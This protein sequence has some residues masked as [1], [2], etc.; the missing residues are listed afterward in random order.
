MTSPRPDSPSPSGGAFPVEDLRSG[1]VVFL[2]A[3]PLCLGIALASGAPLFSGVI[4]GIIGGLVVSLLSSSSVSVSGPAAGLAV[5][6]ATAIQSLGSF[7][8][9]LLAVLIAGIMQIG[10]GL[11]RAGRVA[12]F[13][14][15]AVIKGMLAAIGVVIILKQ[16][17]HA[18]GR[19]KS[20]EG[21][22]DFFRADDGASTTLSDIAD[23]IATANI[24]AVL[25]AAVSLAILIAW[26]SARVK[27]HKR[28][29][30]IPGALLV[31][32]VGIT[33]NEIFRAFFTDFYLRAEDGHL[34][35]LPAGGARTLLAQITSPDWSRWN[36]ARVYSTAITLAVVASI[37][38]L[39]SLEAS[40]KIDPQR[41]ISEPNRELIAQ[42]VGNIAA[43]M[44][45]GLPVTA[46]I[47]RSSAN[48]YAGARTRWSSFIHG[49]LLLVCVVA[50]PALLNR[51]PLASLAAVL[52]MVGYKLTKPAL[53]QT[54]YKA[55]TNQF[56]PFMVT[57]LAIVFTDLLTGVLV[58][59]VFG[60]FFVVRTNQHSAFTLVRQ[61]AM[62][63]LRFNK[64]ASFV[65]KTELKSKLMNLPSDSS[66]II[67][68]TKAVFIDDDIYD[69][70]VD[71][72]EGASHKRIDI[73]FKQFFDKTQNYRK[74]RLTHG[75]A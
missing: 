11:V 53:Y 70:V 75:V 52:I 19:D 46:V 66:L 6:V 49:V 37:Q 15:N 51:I 10:F 22:F 13:V 40:D 73:E 12:D 31:V 44:L 5:I 28:L 25:I 48:V 1:L 69:V 8:A 14:P 16:I 7:S 18:L 36:D 17:P 23:A 68:G 24:E 4:S 2:V 71:F 67:D 55:G 60:V 54:M 42:G 64:D 34:V 57:V 45:G 32:I 50:I 29:A 26:D 62:Y 61:D 21:D 27:Q 35:T 59:L 43:G 9:F 74:R 41:R 38:S 72:S 39:L 58:G 3:L 20:F 30:M 33:M 47:V 56:L 65:N 63:L